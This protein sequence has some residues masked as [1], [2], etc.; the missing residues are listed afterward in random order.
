MSVRGEKAKR[1]AA[2]I[3]LA[4]FTLLNLR[5]ATYHLATEGWK[6]GL[7]ETALTLWVMLLVYLAAEASRRRDSPSW[8]RTHLVVRG[9]VVAIALFYLILS[10]YHFTHQG[11]RSGILELLASLVLLSLSLILT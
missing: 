6:S 3:L 11:I 2:V 7:A 1:V 4:V 10:V 9:W 5:V 8:R